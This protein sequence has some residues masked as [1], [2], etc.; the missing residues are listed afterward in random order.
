MTSIMTQCSPAFLHHKLHKQNIFELYLVKV[1]KL[2]KGQ[3]IEG[4]YTE[5]SPTPT[6][7]LG[8]RAKSKKYLFSMPMASLGKKKNM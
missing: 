3:N 8:G 1:P 2:E 4:S 7:T 5:P 6:T